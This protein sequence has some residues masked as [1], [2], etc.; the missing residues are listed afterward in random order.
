MVVKRKKV[1]GLSLIAT[2]SLLWSSEGIATIFAVSG[3]FNPYTLALYVLIV[4]FIILLPIWLIK[5]SASWSIGLLLLGLLVGG[6]FRIVFAYSILINGA[7]IAAALLH[8]APLIVSL[9]SPVVL[10]IRFDSPSVL[11]AFIAVLGAYVSS[12]PEL[13][14]TTATGFLVG[15]VPAIMYAAQIIVSKYYH[16]KGFNTV[17]IVFQTLPTAIVLPLIT[18]LLLS[19]STISIDPAGLLWATYIGVVC[20]TVTLLLY[21][22]GLKYVSPTIASI[23]ALLE[24]ISALALAVAIL[25]EAYT[26]IQLAGI[27]AILSAT[28]IAT[29]REVK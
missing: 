3:G 4:D 8:I 29:L 5:R 2:A 15:I 1:L 16:N 11:L 9:V 18:T 23:I 10:K 28:S 22:E 24:P 19:T 27:V 20:S 21:I 25:G 26:N 12:N 7:G 6:G 14:L 17:D 13:R